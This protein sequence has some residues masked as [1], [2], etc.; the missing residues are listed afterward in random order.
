MKSGWLAI[1]AILVAVAMN[2]APPQPGAKLFLDTC[3]ACHSIGGGA[4]AGPDLIAVAK[5]PRADIEK[6]VKRMEENVGPL[7]QEQ[8]NALVDLLQAGDAKQQLAEAANPPA[9]EIPPEQKAA[10]AAAGR[11]LFFGEKPFAN[12]GIPCSAC[13]AVA[14]RGGTMAVDLTSIHAQR[15]NQGLLAVAQQPA[16]PLMKAA[17]SAHPITRQEAWHLLAFFQQP[18]GGAPA[19]DGLKIVHGMAAGFTLAVLEGVVVIVRSRRAG[20]RSKMVRGSSEGK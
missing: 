5:R 4:M 15:G 8:I 12:R 1:A 19:R 17:Y 10:S 7:N 6:A 9:V 14:G 3:A 2:A 13:H 18:E 20:V 11:E 16:F